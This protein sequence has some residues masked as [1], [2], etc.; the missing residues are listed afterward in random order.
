LSLFYRSAQE[1]NGGEFSFLVSQLRPHPNPLP[2]GEG[3]YYK[4]LAQ[5]KLL[6][7][8]YRFDAIGVI[9]R[10]RLLLCSHCLRFFT[11]RLQGSLSLSTRGLWSTGGSWSSCLPAHRAPSWER[12]R[13]PRRSCQY[14]ER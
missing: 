5:R 8:L 3:V 1:K 6:T 11:L 14:R 13:P 2:K 10:H 4:F 12:G 7:T 9:C